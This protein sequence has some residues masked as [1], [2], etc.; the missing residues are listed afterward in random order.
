MMK[1]MRSHMRRRVAAAREKLKK[2][3]PTLRPPKRAIAE[4]CLRAGAV[5][6]HENTP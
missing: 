2:R 3:L 5:A 4:L 6:S 1:T